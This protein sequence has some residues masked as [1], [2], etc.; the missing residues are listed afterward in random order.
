MRYIISNLGKM[1]QTDLTLGEKVDVFTPLFEDLR[2]I[3]DPFSD[4]TSPGIPITNEDGLYLSVGQVNETGF[5]IILSNVKV[6]W[7]P[8]KISDQEEYL[9]YTYVDEIA[10]AITFYRNWIILNPISLS[11]FQ[12][13]EFQEF[14]LM[15][16]CYRNTLDEGKL[17]D[18]VSFE[19]LNKNNVI[20]V[21]GYCFTKKTIK[22]IIQSGRPKN[23]YTNQTLS[24]NIIEEVFNVDSDDDDID[25]DSDDDNIYSVEDVDSDDD[26]F[27]RYEFRR[28]DEREQYLVHNPDDYERYYRDENDE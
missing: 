23:P 16:Q 5:D 8:L 19:P 22:K 4:S 2:L 27:E 1:L 11:S 12:I 7:V 24:Q 25:S 18:N 10:Y 3:N 21:D 17:I 20:I 6:Y 26:N 28:N 14:S 9:I 15:E 13:I